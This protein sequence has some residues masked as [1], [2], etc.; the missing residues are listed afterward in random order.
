MQTFCPGE[1]LAMERNMVEKNDPRK[2]GLPWV[3]RI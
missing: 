3:Q 1:V 2:V